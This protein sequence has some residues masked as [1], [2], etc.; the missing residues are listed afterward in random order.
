MGYIYKMMQIP[1]TI[2]MRDKAY[3][4]HEAAA[5]LEELANQMAAEGWQYMRTD[6]IGVRVNPGCLGKLFG[7]REQELVYYVIIFRKPAPPSSEAK[8]EAKEDKA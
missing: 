7:H 2:Q 1:P 5:Y 4:G 6:P 8:T 3:K